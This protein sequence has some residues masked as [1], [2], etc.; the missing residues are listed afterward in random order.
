MLFKKKHKKPEN[1][2]M[3]KISK[4]SSKIENKNVFHIVLQCCNKG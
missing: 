2:V 1:K 4:I 3:T